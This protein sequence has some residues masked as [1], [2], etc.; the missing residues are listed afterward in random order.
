[1][2]DYEKEYQLCE[3]ACGP[4]FDEFV[5][6]FD[7]AVTELSVLDLGC[8]QG[9]DTLM[10]A[11]RGHRVHAVDLAP[12]GISQV[13]VQAKAEELDISGEVADV[14]E[15]EMDRE[16]DVVILD[17]VLHMLRSDAR[18]IVLLDKVR[19]WVRPG[20]H[21][22]VVD[23]RSH[24]DLIRSYFSEIGWKPILKKKDFLFVQRT[25]H[26]KTADSKNP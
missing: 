14:E 16:Y 25:G 20:G 15:I 10:A 22:L 13:I 19:H 11:R 7:S 2:T 5:A 26:R 1:M 6:F 9:R 4:P 3:N 23:T 18:R 8:G 17:R 24:R 21:A 12:T